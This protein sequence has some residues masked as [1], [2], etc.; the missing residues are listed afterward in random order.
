MTI[1]CHLSSYHNWFDE[2]ILHKQCKALAR[3]GYDVRF[4]VPGEECREEDGVTIIALPRPTSKL[5]RL[6]SHLVRLFRVALN[7][8]AAIYQVHDPELL[9]VAAWLRC[10]GKTVIYDAHEDY[11]QKLRSRRLPLGLHTVLSTLWWWCESLLARGAAH[12]L[13]ADGHT[14]KKFPPA[15]V[16]PLPNFPPVRFGE[17][18]RGTPVAAAPFRIVYVG[19]MTRDRGLVQVIQALE[20]LGDLDVEFHI[21]GETRDAWLREYL[22]RPRVVY[23]GR[24]PWREV[25]VFLAAG[26]VGVVMLQPVPAYTYCPGENIVKLWEYM[27]VGLPV[28]VSDFPQ[29]RELMRQ[30]DCGMVADPTS[31]RAI[32]DAIRTLHGS[33]GERQRLGENGSRAV[34]EHFNWENQE[35]KLLD[36]YARLL[37]RRT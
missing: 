11:E 21:A 9:L 26:H 35:R 34:R 17:V 7:Q 1:I 6:T 23:H 8:N 2:R 28:V 37:S 5:V 33:P 29:L 16:T 22:N 18:T 32:A 12:V 30:L 3:A 27:A 36:L 4:V 20:Y 19:G 24:I 14:A 15:K 13:T 10:R 25:N 31:P